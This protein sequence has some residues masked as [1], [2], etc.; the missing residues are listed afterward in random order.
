MLGLLLHTG[1]EKMVAGLKNATALNSPPPPC[2]PACQFIDSMTLITIY[3]SLDGPNWTNP[4]MILTDPV[5]MWPGVT[6]N[7]NGNVIS[8]VLNNNGL[9]GSIPPDISNLA[10]TLSVLQIDNNCIE[11]PIT[12]E[13]GDC[14]NL[15]T[16]F[17]DN[18]KLTGTIPESFGQLT[19]LI[20]LFLD[21]NQL[22]GT[23]PDTFLSMNSLQNLDIFNN[24]FD[25][26]PDLSSMISLQPNKFR[27][28]NNKLTFDDLLP[29]EFEIGTFYEPQDSFGLPITICLETGTD[30]FIDLGIDAGVTTNTYQWF[31]GGTPYATTTTNKLFFSPVT[32]SDAGVYTAN[33][34][35]SIM[36]DLTLNGRPITLKVICGQSIEKIDSTFCKGSGD[37]LVVGG[38]VFDEDTPS[39]TIDVSEQDIY[40]CDS[41]VVVDLTYYES[42][43]VM[44][45]TILCPGESIIVNGTEY[46]ENMLS[47]T[48]NLGPLALFGCDSTVVIDIS[49]YPE[50]IE[51]LNPTICK[52]DSIEVNGIF[53][54]FGNQT[55]TENLGSIA[56]HNCDSIVEVNLSFFPDVI[57][58]FDDVLC[59]GNSVTIGGTLFDQNNTSDTIILENMSV[60]N[61]CDSILHIDLTFGQGVEIT[62][63]D[64]LCD[65]G[66]IIVN[67]TTYDQA[68]PM[69][70]ELLPSGSP[71]ECDTTII[72]ELE[73]YVPDTGYYSPSICQGGS[74]S[75]NG[76]VYNNGM[77]SGEE[78]IPSQLYP[79]CDSLVI[80][81]LIFLPGP[82]SNIDTTICFGESIEVNGTNYDMTMPSGSE[83][84]TAPGPGFCDSV[85]FVNVTFFDEVVITIDSTLCPD[86][87]IIVDGTTCDINNPSQT[88]ILGGQSFNGCDSTI[89][90]DLEFFPEAVNNID[91]ILCIGES[92]FIEGVEYDETNDSGNITSTNSS[93]HGCDST[94]N[95]TVSYFPISENTIKDTLCF[96]ES[97][98]INTTSYDASNPT[99]TI[100]LVGASFHDCDS[101]IY[102]DLSFRPEATGN[103]TTTLCPGGNINI[104]GTIYD[105]G[106]TDGV[107]TLTMQSFHG[108]D[109][110]LTVHVDFFNPAASA[111]D[112]TLCFG[113]EITIGGMVFNAANP[114]DIIVLNAAN[115]N[116]CDS[117]IV[118][119]V[120]FY[121]EA[122]ALFNSTLCFGQTLEINNIVYTE[123]NPMG[124]DT[125]FGGSF[126]GCDSIIEVDLMYNS[127]V[128]VTI[129]DDFCLG[130]TLI[131][132][133]TE[134][135]ELM[136]SGTETITNGSVSGCDSVIVVDLQY[137]SAAAASTIDGIYCDDV[138]FI[139]NGQVYDIDTPA[140]EEILGGASSFGCD[141]TITI[142][143][144]FFAPAV[145]ELDTTL[146][147]GGSILV[148]GVIY[149]SNLTSGIEILEDASF[150]NCDSIINVN[151]DFYAPAINDFNPIWCEGQMINIEGTIY[152]INNP[153]DTIVLL[154]QSFHGCDSIIYI[155]ISFSDAVEVSL[156]PTLCPGGSIIV[157][158]TIY[159][160][161]NP[162]GSDTIIGGSF[163]GCDSI[164]NVDLD[165][166]QLTD[167]TF[168]L[169]QTLCPGEEIDVNGTIYDQ[170]N[171]T[172][173]DTIIGGSYTGCD[174]IVTINLTFHDEAILNYSDTICRGNS[175]EFN[176]VIYNF[177]NPTGND[178][179]ENE[180]MFG[181]DSFIVVQL[182][183]FDPAVNEVNS[184]FCEG[185]S[186]EINGTVYDQAGNYLDTIFSGNYL[187]CDSILDIT[188]SLS[189]AISIDL[190]EEICDGECYPINGSCHDTAG[191]YTEVFINGS[192]T[193]CDSIVNLTLIVQTAEMLGL[194]DAGDDLN[195]C[196]NSVA[197][198]G[199][200]PTGTS[201]LWTSLAP[202]DAIISN[203]NQ[204]NTMATSLTGD[205]YSFVWTL[206]SGV[207]LNYDS[208]TV[209]VFVESL[210]EAVDDEYMAA[211]GVSYLEMSLLDNDNLNG[212]IDWTIDIPNPPAGIL[213]DL[214]DGVFGFEADTI[215]LGTT[216]TFEYL[217]CNENC[218]ECSTAIVTITFDELPFV[219]EPSDD[220]PNGI[221][222]NGDG[223]NDVFIIPLLED[224]PE[225]Y[226][227]RELIVFNRWGNVIFQQQPYSNDWDGTNQNGKN[228][229]EGTY[230][231]IFRL[232]LSK[233]IIYKGDITIL[234]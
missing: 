40:G 97:L 10:A 185:S 87:F 231:Y 130:E 194:A 72:I 73:F 180:A 35:N 108:C 199:N 220:F 122:T 190:T 59:N 88:F 158:G 71:S 54:H 93:F 103:F 175:V 228:L 176:G 2:S 90:V 48:E 58:V 76:T 172:G 36:T 43:P 208:D 216:V 18:N 30:T 211:S 124:F 78:T 215:L 62:I 210:P 83:T 104:N 24:C 111:V 119:N 70:S 117:T 225:Q 121:P 50:A 28:Q 52:G 16:L 134:Y 221:T 202:T 155:N 196:D 183:F 85:V 197:L 46:D 223:K 31:R 187:G 192:Y 11:G 224:N 144:E 203:P 23:V 179:L 222:P 128:E 214:G 198:S 33:V 63:D 67:G 66:S 174:S 68:S 146:C 145:N 13:I 152:D 8:L 173:S 186:V 38:M 20:T 204:A 217:L 209:L 120:T 218:T 112:T 156:D 61:G 151:I 14:V 132:N 167:L 5:C 116:N 193:G 131:V 92:I 98:T 126:H 106:M 159:D 81:E 136:P 188:I 143:L 27:V 99:D 80:V 79:Q 25:S 55:G 127:S 86:A 19:N 153:S 232:D 140:G 114:S 74:I 113:D 160:E 39:G 169:E 34:T 233:G 123:T 206:S 22:T 56:E 149:D 65:G 178:I 227:T 171:P 135:N 205:T 42:L 200:S 181:C 141:S 51:M 7:A 139:V 89:I 17:L 138:F 195:T 44:I 230:Y 21:N 129:D 37:S 49:Y 229:P 53:Y 148:N 163:S 109:S 154:G 84:F 41:I 118:V 201:G 115:Y 75:F 182:F 212:V 162:M 207:C 177:E 234:R 133:G 166:Y 105:E 168:D 189:P 150:H 91:T 165:F 32:W 96:G 157:A 64:L 82:S 47:G 95:I 45:D 191:M 219:E 15:Q 6:L 142:D 29:N 69:G 12:P 107:E 161:S 77:P 60:V 164:I 3:N 57:A 102:I 100:V 110:I 9:V 137:P 94:I 213:S 184:S 4:W 170:D 1:N 226:L 125:I 147:P 26:I 101:T